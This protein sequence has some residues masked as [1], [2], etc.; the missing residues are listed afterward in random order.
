MLSSSSPERAVHSSR[1]ATSSRQHCRSSV[2]RASA[3]VSFH[4]ATQAG[5]VRSRPAA[6]SI[7]F[8]FRSSLLSW[9]R[10]PPSCSRAACADERPVW[11]RFTRHPGALGP[12]ME[13]HERG[14]CRVFL[15]LGPRLDPPGDTE[16]ARFGVQSHDLAGEHDLV[17]GKGGPKG[18]PHTR[19]EGDLPL[20]PR[21]EAPGVGEDAPDRLGAG[22]DLDRE[23]DYRS[24]VFHV[25]LLFVGPDARSLD[26]CRDTAP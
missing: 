22:R 11:R 21:R 25:F 5:R 24:V 1:N 12:H 10:Q 6:R 9:K 23:L 7:R 20:H 4:A 8:A 17:V 3:S 13:L 2:T 14:P 16:A 19:L 15:G 18:A 26:S